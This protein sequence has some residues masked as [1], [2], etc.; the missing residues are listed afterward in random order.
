MHI[1][2]VWFQGCPHV[3]EARR[4]LGAAL[5]AL[6]RA[7]EWVEWDRESPDT[8]EGLRVYG[9]PTV[10]VDGRD[11]TGGGGEVSGAACRADG[12]PTVAQIRGAL[13][14]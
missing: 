9:S 6:G 8:P 7:P 11:V 5:E 12:A 3:A 14:T 13:E 1:A 4:N 10:L 2:L